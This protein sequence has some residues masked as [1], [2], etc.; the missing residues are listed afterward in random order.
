MLVNDSYYEEK[1][2]ADGV[3]TRRVI[4]PK[5]HNWQQDEKLAYRKGFDNGREFRL[6]QKLK[7]RKRYL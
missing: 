7:R 4:F 3:Q 2:F 6:A 1:G 5:I